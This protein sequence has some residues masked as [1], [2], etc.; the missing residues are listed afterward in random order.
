M[1]YTLEMILRS[2]NNVVY[3]SH[4]YLDWARSDSCGSV[5]SL[6]LDV[7]N[8]QVDNTGSVKRVPH[9]IQLII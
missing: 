6:T 9:N 4:A 7:H 1:M 2:L 8:T 3:T 5:S